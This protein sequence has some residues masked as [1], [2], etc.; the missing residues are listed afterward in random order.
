M[1][2]TRPT[3]ANLDFDTVKSDIITYFQSKEEFKDY[4]FTG[5][6]LN[7]LIDILS[8]NTHYYSLASNFLMNESFLD[9]ALIRQNVVSAAK[10]LNYVPR[11]ISSAFTEVTVAAVKQTT[12]DKIVVIPAGTPFTSTNGNSSM[13]FQPI[14]DTTIQ[15]TDLDAVGTVKTATVRIYQGKYA[16]QRFVSEKNYT[17][18][19]KFN[20]GS[21]KIDT[22]TLVVSVNSTVYKK[23]LPEDET[24]FDLNS[25]SAVYFVEENRDGS[26][27]LIFGNGIAGKA[28]EKG[29]EIRVSYLIS[30]GVAGNGV[31]SFSVS[32][33]GR[34]DIYIQTVS[35][36]TQGGASKET[37]ESIRNNAPKWFQAQYRAVT[38][39]DYE[40]ILRN[41]FA[42]IQSISVYGGEDAGYPGK[43]F[44]CIK[45]KSAKALNSATKEVLKSEIIKASNIVTIRPDFVDP[46]IFKLELTTVVVFDQSK[47]STSREILKAKVFTLFDTINTTYVGEFLE[48]FRE[49]NLSYEIKLLDPSVVSSNTRV[50]MTAEVDIVSNK[51]LKYEYNFN[52]KLY[53]PFDGFLASEG[54][55]LSSSLFYRSGKTVQSGFD[56]DG[57]GNVRLYDFIDN[58]K[59]YV[60]NKAGSIDYNTGAVKFLY[61]FDFANDGIFDI[62]VVTDSVDIIATQDM[63]LEIDSGS[64]S[65]EVVEI[66]ETDILKNINLNRSF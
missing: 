41:K 64:S 27:D 8:Y 29:D 48:S 57:Y 55:V 43:V 2:D 60:N 24:I 59:V 1:A 3:V 7:L 21:D 38:T 45:P 13:T 33:S 10:R 32:V 14:E 39:N 26:P 42:D 25:A 4:N 49:S 40:V 37:T 54:G 52:N 6:S 44:I 63:I 35:G 34:P 22:A 19:A 15:F 20:L 50:K 16:T 23:V 56:E 30:E 51:F 31:S 58:V 18:F 62:S 28:I 53:H 66:R 47:L 17:D 12:T 11:S 36:Q 46:S 65:V 61:D 5:S 9:T